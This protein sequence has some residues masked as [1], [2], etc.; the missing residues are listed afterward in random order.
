MTIKEAFEHLLSNWHKQETAYIEKYKSNKS[1]Y[2]AHKEGT[3]K[4][5]IGEKAMR[6]MLVAAKYIEGWKIPKHLK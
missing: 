2:L 3:A 6:E 5:G 4:N 1:K